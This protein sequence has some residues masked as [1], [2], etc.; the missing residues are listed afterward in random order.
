MPKFG[1]FLK[2]PFTARVF[3]YT[4]RSDPTGAPIRT[5]AYA[6]DIKVNVT[7]GVFGKIVVTLP[8]DATDVMEFAQ[9]R[10]LT[11]AQGNEVYPDGVWTLNGLV[12]I[13]TAVSTREG[14]R[15]DAKLTHL[16]G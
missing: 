16:D 15:A 2:K 9:L 7:Q 1:I 12:P 10:N 13:I 5:Y 6:R 11:D 8:D 3:N 4:Q 14:F